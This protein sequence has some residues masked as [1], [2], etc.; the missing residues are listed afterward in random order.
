[1]LSSLERFLIEEM[2]VGRG[3]CLA[4]W[5]HMFPCGCSQLTTLQS[6]FSF[7]GPIPA[8]PPGLLPIFS[9]LLVD[10]ALIDYCRFPFR[11]L[12]EWYLWLSHC[13]IVLCYWSTCKALYYTLNLPEGD[14]VTREPNTNPSAFGLTLSSHKLK[15]FYL[16]RERVV[17]EVIL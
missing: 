1:M 3:L 7:T 2:T 13:V 8:P 14:D 15:W 17:Q 6:E 9:Y 4:W 10:V 16:N 11:G 5:V 12:Y